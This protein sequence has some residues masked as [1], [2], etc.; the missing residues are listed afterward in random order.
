MYF[1]AFSITVLQRLQSKLPSFKLD[2]FLFTHC[3]Y[4]SYIN[5]HA[6]LTAKTV[7]RKS[8]QPPNVPVRVKTGGWG[9]TAHVGPQVQT[10]NQRMYISL[11]Q[12]E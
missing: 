6:K 1:P 8:R 7:G 2:Q 11:K 12:E 5:Q 10:I 4:I 3:L 9:P